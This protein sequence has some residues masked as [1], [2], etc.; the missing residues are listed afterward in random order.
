MVLGSI[1]KNLNSLSLLDDPGP[2]YEGYSF[3]YM[4]EQI[5]RQEYPTCCDRGDSLVRNRNCSS[6]KPAIERGI[7]ELANRL[8]GLNIADIKLESRSMDR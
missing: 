7:N 4:K 3:S 5:S 8:Q 2:P 6:I 1:I